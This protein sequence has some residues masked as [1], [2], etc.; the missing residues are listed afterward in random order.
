MVRETVALLVVAVLSP[1]ACF[2]D[3]AAFSLSVFAVADVVLIH[4]SGFVIRDHPTRANHSIIGIQFV[5]HFPQHL[6]FV[7]FEEVS[8]TRVLPL[9]V[10][11]NHNHFTGYTRG[12][13]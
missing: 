5:V 8:Q 2:R 10:L 6:H 7:F 11:C 12:S 3:A 1:L 4:I 13:T 9:N